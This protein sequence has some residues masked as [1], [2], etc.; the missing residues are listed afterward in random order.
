[1][2]VWTFVSKKTNEIVRCSKRGGDIIFGEEYYFTDSETAIKYSPLWF[3]LTEEEAKIAYIGDVHP[4]FSGTF[5]RP[6]TDRINLDDYEIR[7]FK[8]NEII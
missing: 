3:V 1:M 5:H 8:I 2:E 4:Q 7:S 6:A